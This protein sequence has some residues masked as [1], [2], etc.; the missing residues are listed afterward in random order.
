[1]R[2]SFLLVLLFL[3]LQS[4]SQI[5]SLHY[6]ESKKENRFKVAGRVIKNSVIS[7]PGDLVEM[8]HSISKDWKTTA[9]YSAGTLALIA[10]DGYTTEFWQQYVEPAIDYTL[11]EIDPFEENKFPW[12]SGEDAYITYPLLGLYAGSLIANNEKGQRATANAFKSMMFSYVITHIALKSMVARLRP[13]PSLYDDQ[14]AEY[15]YTRDHWDFGYYHPPTGGQNKYGTSM[16][17]LHATAYFAVA[18]V[19]QMEY[20]NYFIPYS[21]VSVV[22]FAN[23]YGHQHWLSDMLVGGLIGTIIG[24]SVVLNSRKQLAKNKEKMAG[25]KTN[26]LQIQKQLIPRISSDMV[27]LHFVATF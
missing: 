15:P 24:R 11:P 6:K 17:S 8:G 19:M 7:I 2:F 10:T 16:P 9:L 3:N 13:H 14:P 21:F 4:Y 20:D 12:L 27:G 23:L 1:M 18:K 22:F 5:D 25:K 26:K